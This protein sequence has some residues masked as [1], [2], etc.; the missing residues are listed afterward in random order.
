MPYDF[1]D[2]ASLAAT[3]FNIKEAGGGAALTKN[4]V[5]VLLAHP[6]SSDHKHPFHQELSTV[7]REHYAANHPGVA[8]N[9]G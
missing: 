7:I 4:D 9:G 5:Q 1:R 3:L 6:A 2:Q 8:G